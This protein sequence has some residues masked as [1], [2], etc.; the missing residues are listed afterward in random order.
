MS[1]LAYITDLSFQAK[2]SQAAHETGVEVQVV[3][4]LYHFLPALGKKASMV[5]IDLN[6]QG[7]NPNMIIAQVKTKSPDLMVI[8]YAS[9]PKE[10]LL[11]QA[12]QAGADTVLE[13]AELSKNLAGILT[14][15]GEK[16]STA[17][18]D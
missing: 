13:G 17:H 8:A 15:Y 11:K 2:V 14:Q 5:L 4:S 9:Q 16:K 10:E 18:P 7:I 12:R 6:A 3:S 1:V